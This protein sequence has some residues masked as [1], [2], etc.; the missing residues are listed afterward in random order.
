VNGWSWVLWGYGIVT[1]SLV[2]YAW[3]LASRTR[4]VRRRLEELE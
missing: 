4:A 2:V 3:T 1:V